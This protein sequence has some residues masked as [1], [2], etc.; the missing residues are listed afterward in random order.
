MLFLGRR[1][2]MDSYGHTSGRVECDDQMKMGRKERRK[3][4][5]WKETI[6]IQLIDHQGVELVPI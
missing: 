1:N 2:R 5:I 3:G 6:L 4:E